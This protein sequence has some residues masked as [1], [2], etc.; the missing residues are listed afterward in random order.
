[1]ALKD[2]K[3]SVRAFR[4]EY[5]DYRLHRVDLTPLD[6][7]ETAVAIDWLFKHRGGP[8]TLLRREHGSISPEEKAAF[9]EWVRGL[10]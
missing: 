4:A 1:M 7:G 9:Y 3:E 8:P 5:L 2:I 10:R 6:S